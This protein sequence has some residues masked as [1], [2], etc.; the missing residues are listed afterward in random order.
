MQLLKDKILAE[1]QVI[2]R[3][4]L[5]V[6]QFLNHQIDVNFLNIVG[7][8]FYRLFKDIAI[9]KILTVE[10]SGIAVACA[11]AQYF[12]VPV[13]FAKKGLSRNLDE[14]TFISQIYSFTHN[15][16]YDIRVAK[17]FL[18]G[19]DRILIIDDFLANG[20]A[21]MGLKE[22]VNQSGAQL[23]GVGIVIE[24]GFQEGG[25]LLREA[26]VDIKSLVT[27]ESMEAGEIVFA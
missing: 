6:D 13:V 1:G 24:K 27:I 21:V 7:Q 18:S 14:H 20:S 4:T 26:G 9:T 8:E 12:N 19:E 22:I 16:S 15:K 5:K 3:E 10:A 11:A 23:I 2:D 17:K 25:T